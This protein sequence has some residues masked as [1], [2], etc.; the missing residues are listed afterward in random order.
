MGV[1]KEV[2]INVFVVVLFAFGLRWYFKL[3]YYPSQPR[4]YYNYVLK[5]Q[6]GDAVATNSAVIVNDDPPAGG[7][8]ASCSGHG[9][10][11][12]CQIYSQKYNYCKIKCYGYLYDSCRSPQPWGK[13]W[14]ELLRQ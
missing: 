2:L 4:D 1:V 7:C 14:F 11:I 6:S 5:E 13:L 8:R 9:E 12:S 3:I 10:T